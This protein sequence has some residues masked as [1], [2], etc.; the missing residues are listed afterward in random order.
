MKNK[1]HEFQFEKFIVDI[2]QK[3]EAAREKVENHQKGQEDHPARKYN[4]LYR[5]RWQNRIKFRRK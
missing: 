4:K 5:E 1:S 3:E 2:Q